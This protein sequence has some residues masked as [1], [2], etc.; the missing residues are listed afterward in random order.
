MQPR[1]PLYQQM[2]L[3]RA[4]GSSLAGVPGNAV[5]S[6]LSACWTPPGPELVLLLCWPQQPD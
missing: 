3:M 6:V 2:G 4:S 5:S 1:I